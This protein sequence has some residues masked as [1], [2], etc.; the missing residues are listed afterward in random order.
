MIFEAEYRQASDKSPLL[1]IDWYP[2]V[3][4]V[5]ELESMRQHFGLSLHD[6]LGNVGTT[7][8]QIDELVRYLSI[9]GQSGPALLDWV[10]VDG[11]NMYPI[12]D[13]TQNRI[14]ARRNAAMHEQ[15]VRVEQPVSLVFELEREP[16]MNPGALAAVYLDQLIRDETV[17]YVSFV[18]GCDKRTLTVFDERT[19]RLVAPNWPLSPTSLD[20]FLIAQASQDRIAAEADGLLL[21]AGLDQRFVQV[22]RE[23]DGELE[24]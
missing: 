15:S 7:G 21:S 18:V 19:E 1:C 17:A 11:V 23:T 20:H 14:D 10:V 6:V 4:V 9:A 13:L 2:P 16:K 8:E 3:F 24:L 12:T 5:D 22:F